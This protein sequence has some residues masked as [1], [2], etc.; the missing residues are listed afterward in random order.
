[1]LPSS[2]NLLKN[3]GFNGAL[4]NWTTGVY[5]SY[6]TVDSDGCPESGSVYISGSS[7]SDPYQCISTVTPGRQYYVGLRSRGG[8]PGGM[9]RI[10]YFTGAGCTG[11]QTT[12]DDPF[13]FATP[14]DNTTWV[15]YSGGFVPPAGTA[16]ARF[17]VWAWDQ[18]L[19]QM[20]VNTDGQW[21]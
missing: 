3:P 9:I 19:D 8:V 2:G 16:S 13:H 17:A 6:S 4:T 1:M 11:T 15:S 7:D 21:F 20:Y 12:T 14:P 18:W 10:Y 5:S